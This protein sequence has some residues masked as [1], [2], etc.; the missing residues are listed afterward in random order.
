MA[1][2]TEEITQ[3]PQTAYQPLKLEMRA[4]VREPAKKPPTSPRRP[5]M[6]QMFLLMRMPATTPRTTAT[7]RTTMVPTVLFI[8]P[9]ARQREVVIPITKMATRE[10]VT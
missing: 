9:N 10:A 8:Q 6:I 3:K 2:R 4:K 1:A 5:T 7:D